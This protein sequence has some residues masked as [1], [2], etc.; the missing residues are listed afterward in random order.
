MNSAKITKFIYGA[1]I[2]QIH[3]EHF[4]KRLVH[5]V[6]SMKSLQYNK[7]RVAL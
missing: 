2:F 3:F 7:M 4:E 5:I 6:S 1:L